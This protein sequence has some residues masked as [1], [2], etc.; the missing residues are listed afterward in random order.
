MRVISNRIKV[1]EMRARKPSGHRP[2]AVGVAKIGTITLNPSAYEVMGKPSAV[3]LEKVGTRL[4]IVPDDE[5]AYPV[6]N[7]RTGL[8]YR[9]NCRSFVRDHNIQS[10]DGKP[11]RVAVD[12]DRLVVYL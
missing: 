1:S 8:Q 4:F 2:P 7:N 12:A 11:Y 9:L 6:K 3:T 10:S 5:G